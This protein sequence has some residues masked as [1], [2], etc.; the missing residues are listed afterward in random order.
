MQAAS[1]AFPVV[2][3]STLL[4]ELLAGL[5]EVAP[6][7]A[8]LPPVQ[9]HAH[10]QDGRRV[11]VAL[12]L[13]PVVVPARVRHADALLLHGVPIQ[14]G[15]LVTLAPVPRAELLRHVGG[16]DVGVLRAPALQHVVV[17]VPERQE[18]EPRLRARV[19]CVAILPTGVG[20]AD[21]FSLPRVVVKERELYVTAIMT[22]AQAREVGRC[23][24]HFG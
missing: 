23:A 24:I 1:S 11:G 5:R 12:V 6:A 10:G 15:V 19:F 4:S 9:L 14:D 2:A 20:T 17:V 3:W 21:A 22:L 13:D 7:L 8:D 18:G 16:G